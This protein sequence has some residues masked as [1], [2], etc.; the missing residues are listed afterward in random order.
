MEKMVVTVLHEGRER[1]VEATTYA[2]AK[3]PGN[4]CRSSID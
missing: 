3:G 2:P 4:L 1:Q